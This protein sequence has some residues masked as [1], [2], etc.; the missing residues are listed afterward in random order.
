[1]PA[2]LWGLLAGLKATGLFTRLTSP[3]DADQAFALAAFTVQQSATIAFTLLMVFLFLIRRPIVGPRAS[4]LGAAVAIAG[5]WVMLV[6]V[7]QPTR[8]DSPEL[9][10]LSGALILAGV[11]IGSASLLALGR[12][13]GVFPEVRGLVTHG[14][15][16]WVRHPLYLGEIVSSLGVV[17]G[18]ASA[19]LFG[20]FACM[21]VLQYWR[22]R[23]EERV[24]AA[25]FP[26]YEAYSR[27]T[28]RLVPG[29]H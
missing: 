15:Y 4:P 3:H 17:I 6:P 11:G 7:A 23:N 9:L 18:V 26:E 1:M 12:C 10:Y 14:P 28:W 25:A 27:H 2:C 21:C 20:L 13:F 16:R 8:T 19:P 24:L 5:T 29:V 22:A